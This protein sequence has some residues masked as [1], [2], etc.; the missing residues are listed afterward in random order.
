[1]KISAGQ[2]TE[3]SLFEVIQTLYL[4]RRTGVLRVNVEGSPK[5]FFLV[6][7]ELHIPRNHPLAPALD[8]VLK[9]SEGE[10][11]SSQLRALLAKVAEVMAG[12]KDGSYEFL[13]GPGGLPADL[14]GPLPTPYLVMEGVVRSWDEEQL[15]S[16]LG[17]GGRRYVTTADRSGRDFLDLDAEDAKILSELE[18]PASINELARISRLKRP[19]LLE[20]LYR[21]WTFGL[22]R[23]L[24]DQGEVGTSFASPEIVGRFAE[25]I[26]KSLV[27]EPLE[28][29]E[30]EHRDRVGRLLR[31]VGAMNLYEL[32]G[33][34]LGSPLEEVHEA[35]RKVARWVHPSNAGRLGLEG[36]PGGLRLLFGQ[37]TEAYLT[38]SDPERRRQYTAEIDI[39][40]APSV[41]QQTAGRQQEQIEL[42]RRNFERAN[43]L[44]AAGDYHFAIEL[45]QQAVVGDPQAQYYELLG[46]C[47]AKNPK[48]VN[49]A[50]TSFSRA[51]EIRPESASPRLALAE[52]YEEAGDL[53]RARDQFQAVLD[54][55]PGNAFAAAGLERVLPW[56]EGGLRQRLRKLF[57][58]LGQR[59]RRET[60]G[61]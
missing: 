3:H 7:G 12:W 44:I 25:R 26:A 51:I 10:G 35:Y 5:R 9:S 29:D 60:P 32:L 46:S 53:E 38:L 4:E 20:K 59:L 13:D 16:R 36:K 1:M 2:L 24:Q 34:E 15:H 37:A 30:A 19:K 22:V 8:Q 14:L 17:G 21:L 61:R 50:I 52:L 55:F 31:G 47:Q 6:S 57:V 33:L 43:S 39:S 28:I 18:H 42:A 56:A 58:H 23:P 48:W 49:R 27:E 45:L 41:S 11:F 40:S 54:L